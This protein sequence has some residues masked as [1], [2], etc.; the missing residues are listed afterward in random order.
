MSN[1]ANW[2]YTNVA[3]VWPL[4][5]FDDFNGVSTYG[6][7]YLIACTWAVLSEVRV[8]GDGKEFTSNSIFWTEDARPQ[9]KD[10]IVKLDRRSESWTVGE[11]IRSVKDWDMSFFDEIP[12]YALVT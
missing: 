8:D 1:T 4:L 2:S 12:D 10:R 7:P 11:Q 9:Y 5:G 6:D 3:T